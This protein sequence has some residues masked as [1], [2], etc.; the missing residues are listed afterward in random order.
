MHV[1][2]RVLLFLQLE[3]LQ[4][5]GL[6]TPDYGRKVHLISVKALPVLLRK[7]ALSKGDGVGELF[8]NFLRNHK[9]NLL[10]TDVDDM[11]FTRDEEL[12]LNK[13]MADE[14]FAPIT[15][16]ES[17][18][19]LCNEKLDEWKE[20]S[21]ISHPYC[22]SHLPDDADKFCGWT[23]DLDSDTTCSSDIIPTKQLNFSFSDSDEEDTF[24]NELL[25]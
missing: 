17:D 5:K 19:M 10:F 8:S 22:F 20:E 14:D 11:A 4:E 2:K 25:I 24:I 7:F 18:S 21:A 12:E 1:Q 16:L 23:S 13:P 9:S 15:D 6:V 3:T